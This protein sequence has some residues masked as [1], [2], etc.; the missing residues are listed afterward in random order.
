[1]K[2]SIVCI[3]T[4]LVAIS[5]SLPVYAQR[6]LTGNWEW[7]S[8]MDKERRQTI[9]GINLNPKNGNFAGTYFFND[10]QDGETESDGAVAGFIGTVVG[11]V[12]KNRVRS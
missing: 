1:M 6:G 9:F 7:K 8:P 11:N 12:I 10:L 3:F 2:P 5:P 4:L